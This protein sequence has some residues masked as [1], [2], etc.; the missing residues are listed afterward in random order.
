MWGIV[1]TASD[2]YA[3]SPT[4]WCGLSLLGQALER[5]RELLH[6]NTPDG[7]QPDVLA[8][9]DDDTYNRV[10]EVDPVTQVRLDRSSLDTSIH[11]P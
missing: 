11:A 2:S 5:T 1:L 7:T 4:T 8:S 9:R 3:A 6:Q 10:F